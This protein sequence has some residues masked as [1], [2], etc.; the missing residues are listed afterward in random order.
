MKERDGSS[1]ALNSIIVIMVIIIITL[2]MI[3]FLI[4]NVENFTAQRTIAKLA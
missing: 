1:G 3:Q 2:I 4:I